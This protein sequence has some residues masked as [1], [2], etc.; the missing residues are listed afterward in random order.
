MQ[1]IFAHVDRTLGAAAGE[2]CRR[3]WSNDDADANTDANANANGNGGKGE[4]W[5]AAYVQTRVSEIIEAD[6]GSEE[7]YIEA[8][9]DQ[10]V[11][12]GGGNNSNDNNNSSAKPRG[13]SR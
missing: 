1:E 12:E 4:A 8:G 11:R 9:E 3:E 5:I 6:S 2:Q 7:D 10:Q 13:G